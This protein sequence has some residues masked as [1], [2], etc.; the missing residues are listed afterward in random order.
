MRVTY[1]SVP[2]CCIQFTSEAT[3]YNRSVRLFSSSSTRNG[4]CAGSGTRN[5]SERAP[6][7]RR[8]E[9]T[10]PPGGGV[11]GGSD[12]TSAVFTHATALRDSCSRVWLPQRAVAT[13]VVPSGKN[14]LYVPYGTALPTVRLSLVP[15]CAVSSFSTTTAG[16]ARSSV[17]STSGQTARAVSVPTIASTIASHSGSAGSQ[18]TKRSTA[19]GRR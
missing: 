11:A 4:T 14:Q 15:V 18:A 5:T 8:T 2:P 9:P 10:M 6:A 19:G 3:P 12:T 16:C 7:T 17:S 1:G 13:D